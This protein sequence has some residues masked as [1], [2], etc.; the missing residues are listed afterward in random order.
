[1]MSRAATRWLR[2]RPFPPAE[3]IGPPECPI[4]N[5]WTL[6]GGATGSAS[7]SL[8]LMVH[9][10]L[11][12]RDDRDVHDH[13]RPFLTLV[14]WGGYDDL[15]PC[16]DCDGSGYGDPE[17]VEGTNV[18]LLHGC[19]ICRG[20]G[21]VVGDRMRPGM[22]KRRLA[23]HRHRTRV[24]EGGCWTLVLMGPLRRPWGFWREGKWWP[25]REYE[26]RFGFGMRC[27]D[28]DVEYDGHATKT[29]SPR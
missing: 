16:P 18:P 8:K 23:H 20:E 19:P 5:R 14:L 7:S 26:D 10:F 11:P 29:V 3:Q 22:L 13:P 27:E 9:H 2:R 17:Y 25:W 15:V 12:N 6:I 28:V 21:V 4:L 24:G 1:M